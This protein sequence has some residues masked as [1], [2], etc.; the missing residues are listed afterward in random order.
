[1]WFSYIS[2]VGNIFVT[3]Y[4]PET[5]YC[6]LILIHISTEHLDSASHVAPV[7]KN[8][9]ANAGVLRATDPYP[10]LG[11]FPWR[12][13][14]QPTPVFLSGE[15]HG[16]TSLV[17]HD[18]QGHKESDTAETTAQHSTAQSLKI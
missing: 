6:Y 13:V 1:M 16:Q 4:L 15:S 2:E 7:V 12:R 11:R 10:G 9:P 17:G 8:L 14:P 3:G 5:T 18:P